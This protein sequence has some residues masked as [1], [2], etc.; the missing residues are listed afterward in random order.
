MSSSAGVCG[1]RS[2][3]SC[4]RQSLRFATCRDRPAPLG[5]HRRHVGSAREPPKRPFPICRF[6]G[7][8]FTGAPRNTGGQT[9][10]SARRDGGVPTGLILPGDR[11][12]KSGK[13][14][15]RPSN[16]RG[17]RARP[18]RSARR[19]LLSTG[20]ARPT[21]KLTSSSKATRGLVTLAGLLTSGLAAACRSGLLLAG[22]RPAT[23]TRCVFSA[24]SPAPHRCH[25]PMT[26]GS[27]RSRS[28]RRDRSGLSPDSL[29]FRPPRAAGHQRP[30]RLI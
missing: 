5:P 24:D 11:V 25:P 1:E 14:F 30:L 13:A 4:G 23:P 18:G 8:D 28:Q 21:C 15:S 10:S 16:K 7:H 2:F 19:R 29:F 17:H 12:A 3:R 22:R 20:A 6:R 27:V 26:K 9:D